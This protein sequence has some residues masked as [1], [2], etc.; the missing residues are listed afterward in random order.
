MIRAD[1]LDMLF[2]LG[3]TT[4]MNKLKVMA[5]RPAKRQASWV[6]YPHSAGPESID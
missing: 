5:Y 3:G 2:E 6:G 1:G 4:H